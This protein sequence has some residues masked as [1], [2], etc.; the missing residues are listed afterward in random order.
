MSEIS[1]FVDKIKASI[2]NEEDFEKMRL[3][4]YN[5]I[6]KNPNNY[7]YW[8]PLINQDYVKEEFNIAQ[9]WIFKLPYSIY[10]YIGELYE[11]RFSLPIDEFYQ[12]NMY[13]KWQDYIKSNIKDLENRVYSIKTGTLSN[14]F[15]F[16]SCICYKTEIPAK[17]LDIL[18]KDFEFEAEGQSEFI[19][20]E[21]IKS[22]SF[23][24][25]IYNGMPLNTEFRVFYDFDIKKIIDI[26]NYW[27]YDYCKDYL[28]LNDKIVFE[29]EQERLNNN[30]NI[31]KPK[32]QTKIDKVISKVNLKGKWSIDIMYSNDKFWLIDMAIGQQSAYWKEEYNA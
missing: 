21:L 23:I 1:D 20:R 2:P 3:N 29:H 12:N 8:F 28:M 17:I 15:D 16:Q 24:P 11:L 30:F 5:D 10:K 27:N 6:T 7:S 14:K 31:L 25:T 32:I 18:F 22:D 4:H 26:C 19:I 9:S 13:K